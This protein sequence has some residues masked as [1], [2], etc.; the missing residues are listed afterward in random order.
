MSEVKPDSRAKRFGDKEMPDGAT[1]MQ[2]ID[3]DNI[4]DI[5]DLYVTADYDIPFFVSETRPVQGTVLELMAGTGRL[6]LPLL[7]SGAKLTCVDSSNAMLEVLS[8]KLKQRGLHADIVCADV[9]R[10][11]LSARFELAILPFQAFMEIVGEENQRAALAAVFKYLVP[12]G[13]FICTLHNPAVRRKQVDGLLRLVGHFPTESGALVVSG[14]EQGGN[15]V[16]SRQQFF[17]FFDVDGRLREKRLLQMQFAFVEKD[18]FERMAQSAGFH[19]TQLYGNYDRAPF[20]PL[21]SP[22][23][24]WRFEKSE[25]DSS[26]MT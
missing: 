12:G 4:A 8:R 15:P 21:R 1:A 25:K 9:C 5:Y 11:D 26:R 18:E 19:V 23:M 17:E 14:F 16:V 7:E 24:I 13:R 6:S 3:Y 20:D 2:H 22:V 10:L